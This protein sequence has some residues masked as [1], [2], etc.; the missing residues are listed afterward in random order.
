MVR[1]L[2]AGF[3]VLAASLAP[4]PG[5]A[6][7][8]R[9]R[10]AQYPKVSVE[11]DVAIRM[12][13]GLVLRADVVH[14]AFADGSAAPGRFP[15]LLT[16]TPYNK[17]ATGL[18]FEDDYL[19][20]RGYT[21]VIVDVRGTG[22]SPGN[23]DSFGAREQRDGYELV[24]WAASLK[25]PWSNGLVGLHGTS[26]GAINQIFTAAQHP[27]G[28]RAAFPI[29]PMGDSYR[30]VA[31]SGGQFDLSFIPS[32]LG[33]VTVA[34]LATFTP[35][36]PAAAVTALVQHA[37]NVGSF[38]AA[39]VGQGL[40]GGDP[41]Y[42]G[43]FYR[44]RSPIEVID[45]VRVPTFVVGGWYDLFQRS[46]PVL[47]QHLAR[48]HVPAKLLM[49]PWYHTSTALNSG[50][51]A[52]GVPTLDELELR[53]MDHYVRGVRDTTLDRDIAPVTLYRLG[54]GHYERA[55]SW[56][57]RGTG[58]Q[59]RYLNGNGLSGGTLQARATGLGGSDIVPWIPAA[60][61]CS[62]STAQWTAAGTN[63]GC[64][65][66]QRVNDLLGVHYDMPVAHDTRLTGPASAH[67]YLTTNGKDAPVT[68]RLEDVAPDGTSTQLTAG[69]NLLSMRALTM[70]KTVKSGS[71]IVTPYHPFTKASVLPT[72]AGQVMELWVEILPT[73]A[74]IKAGHSLRLAIQQT[75]TPHLGPSLPEE[76]SILGNVLTLLHDPAHPSAVVLPLG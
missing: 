58:Y 25:R 9:A 57:P 72:P 1:K 20:Q 59:P 47:Y 49:G 13:D 54:G 41:I 74:L 37:Q 14:P 10:A 22:S 3:V 36:D 53:W 24:A 5:N 50:L 15:V 16:Q 65:A 23:W 29:V 31:V 38:Q 76:A 71:W 7:V 55:T 51:P 52:D 69:W 56:P 62:R 21:Q 68:V 26:Y 11:R 44:T 75:D 60:G 35:N 66:N 67:L 19:V 73:T 40:A 48:N 12:S 61:I 64:E 46:E 43:P 17:L 39:L 33:L 32:W 27:P 6:A 63:Q 30:D 70:S 4:V 2:L 42:D 8:W 34:S 28:L 45:R 18:N